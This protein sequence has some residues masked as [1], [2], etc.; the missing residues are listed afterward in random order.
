MDDR[1]R[2]SVVASAAGSV[3]PTALL[4]PAE[5]SA[6]RPR[7]WNR[8]LWGRAVREAA[9]LLCGCAML[10][11]AFHWLYIYLSSFVSIPAFSGLFAD[12]PQTMQGMLGISIADAA[13]PRGRIA[14]AYVD[15]T[16]VLLSAVWALTRGS[17][18]VSGPLDRGTLELVL[19]QPVSRTSVLLANAGVTIAGAAVI[20][21]AAWLGTCTGI[22]TVHVEEKQWLSRVVVPLT[23]RVDSRDFVPAAVNLFSLTVFAA[24][25][26]TLISACDRYRWRTLGIA[27]GFYILQIILKMVGNAAAPWKWCFYVTF[28]GAYWPQVL[29]LESE[30]AWSLS[31]R[32]NGLLLGG[33][34]ACYLAAAVVFSR[35]DLPAPM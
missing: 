2:T 33:A 32:Y 13:R 12:L 25:G 26:T 14:L 18:A 17:D 22:A 10:M 7:L 16:V 28:L 23:A 30:Q 19:A 34:A 6:A 9:W 5:S 31:L 4:R 20:A 21:L 35:R 1:R 8:A 29:A 11:F 3:P 24:A 15:P 27:G